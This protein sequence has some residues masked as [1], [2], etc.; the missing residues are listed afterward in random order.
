LSL[1][2]KPGVYEELERKSARLEAGFMKNAAELGIASTI[3][4]VGSMVCPFFTE[5]QV[6]NYET[7]KTSDLNRFRAYFGHLLDLGI[8]VAPSQFEGM[9]VSAVHSDDDIE[10]TINA[11]YEALKKL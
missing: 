10:Q 11:H 4:R 1:L 2:G 9:F 7:A 3:N 6:V 5:R 8:S